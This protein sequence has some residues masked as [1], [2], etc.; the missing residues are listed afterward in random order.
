MPCC[1]PR[2]AEPFTAG[3]ARRDA[4]RYRRRGLDP[5][6]RRLIRLAAPS[7]A[8]LLEIGAGVGALQ[9]AA[10]Q[11]GALL[12]TGVELSPA[13]E[14]EAAALL[15]EHGAGDRAPRLVA[16]LV[17]APQAA[18][19]ADVVLLNRVVCCTERPA[20]LLA[21]AAGHA[22]SRMAFSFPRDVW[23]LRTGQRAVNLVARLQGWGWRF[24]VHR[25]ADLVRAVEAAGLRL[26]RTEH[27][28]VWQVALLVRG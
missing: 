4:R 25:P 7:G 28:L 6:S 27:G 2:G 10:L 12:A 23:W 13:Y 20:A 1:P 24:R 11:A 18:P 9:V 17:V 16:D 19:D 26:E 14:P 21:A 8:R 5:V 22:G 3:M 15:A